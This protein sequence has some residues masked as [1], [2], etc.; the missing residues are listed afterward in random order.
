[1]NWRRKNGMSQAGCA[2]RL[3]LSPSSIFAYEA[4]KR[5]EG[6]VKIPLL[7]SLAMAAISANLKPYEGENQ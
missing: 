7:V 3:G 6:E 4:G 1:M 2:K 5:R